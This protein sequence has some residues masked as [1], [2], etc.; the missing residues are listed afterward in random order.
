MNHKDWIYRSID[1]L[2]VLEEDK[3]EVVK[4]WEE[5]YNKITADIE[6]V[7]NTIRKKNSE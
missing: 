4:F 3:L 6:A 1:D 5:F 2:I 7:S